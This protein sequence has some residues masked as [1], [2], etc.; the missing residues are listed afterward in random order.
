MEISFKPSPR[1]RTAATLAGMAILLL[2]S[3]IN[4]GTD[5]VSSLTQIL[6]S[7]ASDIRTNISFYTQPSYAVPRIGMDYPEVQALFQ[8]D[9]FKDIY[10][11]EKDSA[12]RRF[13]IEFIIAAPAVLLLNTLVLS[14]AG[15]VETGVFSTDFNTGRQIYLYSSS[16]LICG[17]IAWHDY[18]VQ[19][20]KR[21]D[22]GAHGAQLDIYRSRF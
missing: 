22:I 14:I 19:K 1:H 18:I 16:A 12:L 6:I 4:G 15:L 9:V 10:E 7:P 11:V 2:A 5:N 20:R 17:A 13:E 3:S 21:A 8:K